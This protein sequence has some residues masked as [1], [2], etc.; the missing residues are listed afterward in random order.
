MGNCASPQYTSKGGNLSWKS[1]VNVID[2]E[3]KLQQLKEPKQAWHVLSQNP[4][5]F[6]CSSESMYVGSPI[7]H[8][9]PSEELQ[10]GHIYFLL[11]L[12][13]S[14]TT[15]S[16]QDLCALA[17]KANAALVRFHTPTAN[18]T[19][20][21]TDSSLRKSSSVKHKNLLNNSGLPRVSLRV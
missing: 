1:S 16:L 21:A 15:L 8:V 9:G 3:G 13:K 2:M 12:S 19:A 18:S 7:P 11:P 17:V 20:S 10:S 6:M 4:N 14:R 5:F